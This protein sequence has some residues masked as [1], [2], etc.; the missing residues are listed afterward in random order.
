MV[1][2]I[3]YTSSTGY[4]A[5]YAKLLSEATGLPVYALKDSGTLASGREVVYLGW[6]MAGRVQGLSEARKRFRV[7]CVCCVGMSPESEALTH[8]LRLDNHVLGECR[9]FYLQ[10][11]YNPSAVKAP[12]R[13]IM[14]AIC[15]RL[16]R[17]LGARNDLSAGEEATLKM[18]QGGYSCVGSENLAPVLSYLQSRREA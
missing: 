12:Y 18:A 6:L 2:A 3:I 17:E 5:Q 16:R 11:G 4:T 9:L 10:G 1:N 14:K 13:P 15:A 8:K 7:S